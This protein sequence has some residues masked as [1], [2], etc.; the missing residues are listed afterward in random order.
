MLWQTLRGHR[1]AWFPL[2]SAGR[3]IEFDT[4]IILYA[5]TLLYCKIC[6]SDLQE[7]AFEGQ[8]MAFTENVLLTCIPYRDAGPGSSSET[9]GQLVG[10]EKV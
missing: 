6:S 4:S 10:A 2:L 8:N 1:S 9:Q 7:F 3:F 5:L